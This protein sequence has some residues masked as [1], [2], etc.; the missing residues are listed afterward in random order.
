MFGAQRFLAMK[1]NPLLL[2]V[3]AA[4]LAVVFPRQSG[5]NVSFSFFYDNLS[6]YGEW[7]EADGYG[8]CWR[9]GGIDDAWSPY[10]DGYWAYTDAGWTWVSYEDF[11]DITYHYGRWVRIEGYGWIWKPDYEWAPAWVSWRYSDDYVGWAPL[12]PEARWDSGVGFSVWVDRD[13]D[14]GPGYYSFCETRNFGAP[15]LRNV[16]LGRSHNVTYISKTVNITNITV[17]KQKSVIYNGGPDYRRISARS[18]RKIETLKLDRRTDWDRQRNGK[19]QSGHREGNQLVVHAPTIDRSERPAPPP[20]VARKIDRAKVDKGWD[21]IADAKVRRQVEEKMRSETK[22]V[23]R[24][25]SPARPVDEKAFDEAFAARRKAQDQKAA[26]DARPA[27]NDKNDKPNKPE[28]FLPQPKRTGKEESNSR[29]PN[30]PDRAT[31]PQRENR[32]KPSAP[33]PQPQREEAARQQQAD[34]ERQANEQRRAQQA[35]QTQQAQQ[36]ARQKEQQ[37]NRQRDEERNRQRDMQ[38][39]AEQASRQRQQQQMKQKA[40][41]DDRK[42][43]PSKP[44]SSRKQDRQSSSDSSDRKKKGRGDH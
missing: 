1:R 13:Y 5:A 6:P 22:G 35:K 16:L 40:Q 10:T 7:V 21:G 18:S 29:R 34:R 26:A 8:Y 14:I 38:R 3:L 43:P 9:P 33:D 12:P 25:D 2:L 15:L 23:S 30:T 20:R 32:T 4:F 27:R 31:P 42:A 17:N 24:K 28:P 36:A 19:F 41:K 39:Q 44:D 11:G 37:I